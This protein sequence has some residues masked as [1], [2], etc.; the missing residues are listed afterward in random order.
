MAC[1]FAIFGY[2]PA[3]ARSDGRVWGFRV[4]PQQRGD[5]IVLRLEG[6]FGHRVTADFDAFAQ[7]ALATNPAGIVIDLSALDYLSSA[8]LR[9]I[10]RLATELQA[11]KGQV[12]VRGASDAV[13]VTLQLADFER[14][15]E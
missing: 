3:M 7:R 10:V 5:T 11:R 15:K 2:I 14:Q 9:A 12:I 13:R 8:G 1:L 4:I 6:R